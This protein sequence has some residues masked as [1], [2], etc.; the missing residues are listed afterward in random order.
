MSKPEYI[1]PLL[2]ELKQLYLSIED[3]TPYLYQRGEDQYLVQYLGH[4]QQNL[5]ACYWKIIARNIKPNRPFFDKEMRL[6]LKKHR[7]NL[8]KVPPKIYPSITGGI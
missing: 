6:N 8:T 4:D 5:R 7:A 2:E 1:V 3:Y